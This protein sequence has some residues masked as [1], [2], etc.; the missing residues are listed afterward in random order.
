ML[1]SLT[2][3]GSSLKE[4]VQQGPISRW[5][6]NEIALARYCTPAS[7]KTYELRTYSLLPQKVGEFM[8]LSHEKFHLR[9][10]HSTVLGYW[11]TELGG[12]NEVVHLWEYDSLSSRA[13]VRAKL[14]VDEAWQR[15]YFQLILPMLQHQNNLTLTSL[16]PPASPSPPAL[17]SDG[18]CYELWQLSMNCMPDVWRAP[19]LQAIQ[20]LQSDH[21]SLCGAFNSGFGAMNSAV[22]IWQHK[23]IDSAANLKQDLFNSSHGGDLW[24]LVQSGSSKLMSPTS[25]SPWK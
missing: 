21:R 14:G 4:C 10:A 1:R 5:T 3:R 17:T 2:R 9:T 11:T 19:L 18:G 15:E 7:E 22:I 25:F 6:G 13:A 20:D 12:L 8:K 23:H 24:R 16:L